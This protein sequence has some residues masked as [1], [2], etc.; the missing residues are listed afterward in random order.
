MMLLMTIAEELAK[1]FAA[2][3]DAVPGSERIDNIEL[4]EDQKRSKLKRA[5]FFFERRTILCELKSLETDTTDKLVPILRDAGVPLAAGTFELTALIKHRPDY[6]ELY[7]ACMNALTTSVEDGLAQANR[8]IRETK[9]LFDIDEADGLVIFL[10][11]RV[12]VLNPDV[13]MRRVFERLA[14]RKDDGSGPYH[15]SVTAVVLM[16]EIHKLKLTDGRMLSVA[17]PVP[18]AAVPEKFDVMK[19]SNVLADSWADWNGRT[20]YVIPASALR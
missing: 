2:F 16:S 5:D 9:Q 6:D 17:I 1:R 19:F 15:E 8:Q 10:H 13:I 11:G 3:C 4:T 14:K 18:H 12:E 7:R 20:K